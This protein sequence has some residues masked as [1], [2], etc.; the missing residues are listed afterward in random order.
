MTGTT[1]PCGG[2]V[3]RNADEYVCSQCSCTASTPAGVA[4][5]YLK[6]EDAKRK[7]MAS[8]ERDDRWSPAAW[9]LPAPGAGPSPCRS[10]APWSKKQG[11]AAPAGTR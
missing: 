6:K 1:C 2:A 4:R 7:Q 3:Y 11:T 9:D 5:A 8:A 10:E